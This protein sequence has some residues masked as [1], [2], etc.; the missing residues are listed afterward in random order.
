MCIASCI[1]DFYDEGG[2]AVGDHGSN[3]FQFDGLG[4]LHVRNGYHMHAFRIIFHFKLPK[5]IAAMRPVSV[6]KAAF[7]LD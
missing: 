4:D 7:I 6:F 5:G 3:R 2:F 1:A